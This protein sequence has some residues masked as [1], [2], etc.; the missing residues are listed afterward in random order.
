MNSATSDYAEIGKILHSLWKKKSKDGKQFVEYTKN[1]WIFYSED[2]KILSAWF[3]DNTEKK[4][5]KIFD[6]E[7][8]FITKNNRFTEYVRSLV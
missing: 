3:D 6:S 8:K 2:R 7:Y 1:L 4:V 5:H